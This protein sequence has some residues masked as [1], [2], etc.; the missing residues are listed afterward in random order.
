[1]SFRV[2]TTE[3]SIRDSNGQARKPFPG[4]GL[5]WYLSD[6]TTGK[7]SDDG[8]VRL[9]TILLNET[10]GFD[11]DVNLQPTHTFH[12]GLWF[13]DPQDAVSCGFDP[14]KAGKFNGEQK[15]GP[16]VF[17]TV[18]DGVTGLG[19]LCTEPNTSVIPAACGEQ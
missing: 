3:R 11:P 12:I 5:S 10:F 7:R 9:Q 8:H 16:L 19:P 2:F 15:S 6:V 14:T 17:T 13:D 1:M 18:P 4:F